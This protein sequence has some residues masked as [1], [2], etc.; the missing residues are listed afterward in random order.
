VNE[1]V[2]NKILAKIRGENEYQLG[3]CLSTNGAHIEI[4]WLHKKLCQV[5]CLQVSR[6]L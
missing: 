6:I 2:T 3:M 1:S 5:Q 4:C